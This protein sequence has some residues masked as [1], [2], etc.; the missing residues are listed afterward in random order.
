[1]KTH[2]KMEQMQV[3]LK[4]LYDQYHYSPKA[5]RELHMIA[6]ALEEKVLKLSNLHS[7]RWLPYVHRAIKIVCDSYQV[8]LA[9][10][11]DMASTERN[12][13]PSATVIGRAKQVTGHLKNDDDVLFLHFMAD[14][15]NH[16]A[17]L[18]KTFQKDDL[19]VCQAVESQEACFWDIMS[20][21]TEM[22]PQMAK[23]HHAVQEIGE[24]KGV[25]FRIQ[26]PHWK[27]S[28]QR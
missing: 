12:P 10:F 13:K 11:E 5:V 15:L 21:K 16:L 4:H 1:M 24:Y 9:H 17:T 20:L 26:P 19:T 23:V 8:L 2:P 25:R 14:V 22:G 7:A 28:G 6:E 18:S 27:Q 3:K